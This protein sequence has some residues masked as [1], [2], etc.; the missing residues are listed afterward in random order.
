M[1]F[2]FAGLI[3]V[4]SAGSLPLPSLSKPDTTQ[5]PSPFPLH[6]DKCASHPRHSTASEHASFQFHNRTPSERL[7][8]AKPLHESNASDASTS[9]KSHRSTG[10][11]RKAPSAADTIPPPS[12]VRQ[13]ACVASSRA[14]TTRGSGDTGSV[15]RRLVAR[16]VGCGTLPTQAR[17]RCLGSGAGK[18]CED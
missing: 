15:A 14:S 6:L 1:P 17:R 16:E 4:F 18:G 9:R 7:H 11:S 12:L 10:P 8:R 13:D 5:P 3:L 2:L